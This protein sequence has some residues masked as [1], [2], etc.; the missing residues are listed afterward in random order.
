MIQSTVMTSSATFDTEI[1]ISSHGLLPEAHT[2]ISTTITIWLSIQTTH[3]QISKSE[4]FIFFLH[5]SIF[6]GLSFSGW[7]HHPFDHM[8]HPESNF[9][10]P[11]S[12]SGTKSYWFCFFNGSWIHPLPIT[13]N[14]SSGLY[15]LPNYSNSFLRSLSVFSQASS[16]DISMPRPVTFLMCRSDHVSGC[17]LL[18]SLCWLDGCTSTLRSFRS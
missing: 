2:G 16:N 6:C 3:T 18:A 15:F 7:C 1:R 14:L 8:V 5:I 10:L 17:P 11:F 4:W 9:V 12:L 13:S